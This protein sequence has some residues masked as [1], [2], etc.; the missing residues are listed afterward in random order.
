MIAIIDYD[1]GNL[2]S[3]AR[4][5]GFLGQKYVITRRKEEILAADRVIFPGVGA[6]ASAMES[7]NRYGLDL[8]LKRVLDSGRP[9]LGI[10]LGTQ[11]ITGFSEEGHIPCLNL[12]PGRVKA[13]S[14][15]MRDEAGKALKIPHM[16][17]NQVRVT[18][19]HPVLADIGEEDAFY[20][21]HGYYPEPADP[22]HVLAETDYGITFASA[23]GFGNLVATQF[24]PEKSGRPGLR[25]LDNFCR[26]EGK[27]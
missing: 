25:L 24:H 8:V 20:F 2:T 21:V 23:M 14:R 1:A 6:A 22:A 17:W 12:I 11:I 16:G 3:V 18:Q 27:P 7:L 4:A 19:A 5:L 13:F 26:W 15:E 10:C 9:L